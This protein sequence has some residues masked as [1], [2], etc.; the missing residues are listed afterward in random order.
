M[1]YMKLKEVLESTGLSK[2]A[3]FKLVASGRFPKHARY[4]G[5]TLVWE[6]KVIHNWIF[7]ERVRREQAAIQSR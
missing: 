1:S 7:E 4:W 3:L 2:K 5:R 6:E